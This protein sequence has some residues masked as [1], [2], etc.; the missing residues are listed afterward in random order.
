MEKTRNVF[1]KCAPIVAWTLTIAIIY[2]LVTYTIAVQSI[3]GTNQSEM[4]FY[5]EGLKIAIPLI[6]LSI[7]VNKIKYIWQFIFFTILLVAAT[8]AVTS[9]F[10]LTMITVGL[11]FSRFLQK[12]NNVKSVLEHV[13]VVLVV[14][15]ITCFI[16]TGFT[17][18]VF[19]QKVAIYTFFV[20]GF[21]SFA[22]NGIRRFDNY[23]YLRKDK[24]NIPINRLLNNGTQVFLIVGILLLVYIVPVM[25]LAYEYVPLKIELEGEF[26]Q[27]FSENEYDL[28]FDMNMSSSGIVGYPLDNVN[29]NLEKMW[30]VIL[31]ILSIG[32]SALILFLTYRLIR[33]LIYNF[34]HVEVDK[35][36]IIEST[37]LDKDLKESTV[38]KSNK[39]QERLDFSYEM[40]VRRRYK[41]ELKKHKPQPWQTPSEMEGMAQVHIPELH[42]E[43]EKV[44]YGEPK[45][46][47]N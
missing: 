24:A 19:Y 39:W 47:E 25:E 35:N 13:Y 10:G 29:P 36:D 33:N 45:V 28:E 6:I 31:V 42:E 26:E 3:D 30:N 27:E 32:T 9:D 15:P 14:A 23:V 40:K 4:K 8:Y 38:K 1:M 7:S 2:G 16:V 34:H 18:F 21:L 44:R 41:K 11:C 12:V 5:L 22:Y 46:K 17:G 37:F 20:I 43:Y